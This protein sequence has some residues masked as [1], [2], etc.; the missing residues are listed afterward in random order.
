MSETL[1]EPNQGYSLRDLITADAEKFFVGKLTSP[2]PPV[3]LTKKTCNRWIVNKLH[4][5]GKFLRD[6][7]W[8]WVYHLQ[9]FARA[10][11]CTRLT[12]YRVHEPRRS[13][14]NIFHITRPLPL[15]DN[16]PMVYLNRIRSDLIFRCC[17]RYQVQ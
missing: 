3:L 13:C 15:N 14:V 1:L 5:A 17:G 4:Q 2:E 10:F 12:R 9:Q 7:G 16:G 11:N 6:L 8:N